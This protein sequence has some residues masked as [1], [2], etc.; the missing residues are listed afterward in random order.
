MLKMY[1]SKKGKNFIQSL[2]GLKLQAY[3]DQAGIPTIGYGT[4]NGVK[5]G[6]TIT[7]K[8]ADTLFL[9]DLIKFENAMYELIKVSINQNQYDAMVS[10]MYNIGIANFKASTLLMLV[11]QSRFSEAATQFE[12]WVYVT[13]NGQKVVS[14]GLQNRRAKEKQLFLEE[15]PKMFSKINEYINSYIVRTVIEKVPFL[16]RI[17]KLLDGNKTKIGRAGLALTAFLQSMIEFFP[18][19]SLVSQGIVFSIGGISWLLTEL[20][21]RHQE[22]KE[23]RG[24]DPEVK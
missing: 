22:D 2:E 9:R 12:K 13:V 18:Q 20:G 11:N 7:Q 23:A 14:K 3:R 8:E 5:M 6:M 1:L 16:N 24:I 4:T 10:L 19:E 15:K 21:I 17:F